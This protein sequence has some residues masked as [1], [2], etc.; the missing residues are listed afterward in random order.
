[1]TDKF[2]KK[3]KKLKH[4]KFPGHELWKEC[5]KGNKEAWNEMRKYNIHDVLATE[6]LYNVLKQWDFRKY[7]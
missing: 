3:Y 4:K 5:L 6:E 2:C 7:S 1:M